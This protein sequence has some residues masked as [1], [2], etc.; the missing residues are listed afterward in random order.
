MRLLRNG[1]TLLTARHTRYSRS[2]LNIVENEMDRLTNVSSRRIRKAESAR[3]RRSVIERRCQ[4]QLYDRCRHA[5]IAIV[6]V[7]VRNRQCYLIRAYGKVALD[8]DNNNT[9][10]NFNVTL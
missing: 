8:I 5:E 7:G 9:L 2:N 6:S 1:K 3:I 4:L 10:G